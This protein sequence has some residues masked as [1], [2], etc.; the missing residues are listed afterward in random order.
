MLP[1]KRKTA[2]VWR[3][4]PYPGLFQSWQSLIIRLEIDYSITR[5]KNVEMKGWAKN[6]FVHVYIKLTKGYYC[7]AEGERGPE[8]L[9]PNSSL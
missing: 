7:T 2:G 4:A 9:L 5:G 3:L 6:P 8:G 1:D